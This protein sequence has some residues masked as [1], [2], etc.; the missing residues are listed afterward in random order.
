MPDGRRP[1]GAHRASGAQRR[2]AGPRRPRRRW[3][4]PWPPPAP[5]SGRVGGLSGLL[6][7]SDGLWQ[8]TLG[9]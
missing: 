4:R 5:E 6:W 3:P 2:V 1:D 9:S 7:V 8:V